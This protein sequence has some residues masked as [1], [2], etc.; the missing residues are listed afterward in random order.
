MDDEPLGAGL[1][2]DD[3][4]PVRRCKEC[5]SEFRERRHWQEFCLSACRMVWHRKEQAKAL[6]AYRAQRGAP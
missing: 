2:R 4:R 3:D 1:M 6:R 5:G